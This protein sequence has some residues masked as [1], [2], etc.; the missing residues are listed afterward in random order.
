MFVINT[1]SKSRIGE[2]GQKDSNL[3]LMFTSRNIVNKIEYKQWDE[4]WGSDHIPIIFN[5]HGTLQVYTKKSNRCSTKNTDW[6]EYKEIMY[7]RAQEVENDTYLNLTLEEKYIY[8]KDMMI[9]STNIATGR[10]NT[11]KYTSADKD[12]DII[13]KSTPAGRK[14]KN[15]QEKEWWDRECQ[16]S[17]DKRKEL[18]IIWRRTRTMWDFTKYKEAR[19]QT[20][21]L[22]KRKK[23]ESY[24]K[25]I[26]SLNI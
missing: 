4:S 24:K 6:K 16:Q 25:F 15:R 19:A 1:E 9:K 2:G 5:I 22:L 21:K 11:A 23:R 7:E 18:Q 26:E 10:K 20:V 17:V 12:N 13:Q 3:D 14:N 8:I